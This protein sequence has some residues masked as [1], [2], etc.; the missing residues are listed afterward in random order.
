MGN[1]LFYA[2]IVANLNAACTLVR[3][4]ADVNLRE[5]RGFVD[6]LTLAKKHG[7]TELVKLII[8]AGFNFSNML[9]DIKCLKTQN[10]DP[11]YDFMASVNAKPLNLRELCRIRIR[12]ILGRNVIKKIYQLPLPTMLMHYLALEEL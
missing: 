8:Y 11:L 4:G 9:F 1:I 3:Y 12:H 10:D 6:N 7:N 5:E 2:I